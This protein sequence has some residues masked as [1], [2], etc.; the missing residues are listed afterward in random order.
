VSRAL[1]AYLIGGAVAVL[2]LSGCDLPGSKAGQRLGGAGAPNL[3]PLSG[4]VDEETVD[5]QQLLSQWDDLNSQCRGGLG[6]EAATSEACDRRNEVDVR[7]ERQGWCYGENAA[8][9]Y[10]AEWRPCGDP[11]FPS[12]AAA[13]AAAER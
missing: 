12:R 5:V 7:L 4:S 10:Q 6:D 2:G 1:N 9:G 8:H 11:R 3:H 13:E